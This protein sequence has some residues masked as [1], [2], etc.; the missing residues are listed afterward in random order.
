MNVG[1]YWYSDK[2]VLRMYGAREVDESSAPG[3]H[4]M[5]AELAANAGVPKPRVAVI[6]EEAPNAFATG[7]NPEHAVVAV[8]DGI[9]RLLSPEELRGVLNLV[10]ENRRSEALQKESR[11][12]PGKPAVYQ[13]IQGNIGARI[14]PAGLEE[15]RLPCPA[16]ACHEHNREKVG[17]FPYSFFKS[18][19]DIHGASD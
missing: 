10:Y 12:L 17:S 9:M 7:R 6:P 2:I 19:R 14:I 16:W 15:G 8:T 1:A 11:I 4:A 5:V 13:D 3:L 18:S